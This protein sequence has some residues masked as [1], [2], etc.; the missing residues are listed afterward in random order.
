M[1]NMNNVMMKEGRVISTSLD[2]EIKFEIKRIKPQ[3]K[4]E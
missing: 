3:V 1:P 2:I 4:V